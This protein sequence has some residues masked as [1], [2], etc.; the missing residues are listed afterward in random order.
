M[1]KTSLF[2]LMLATATSLH[3]QQKKATT[4]TSP[5]KPAAAASKL[6]KTADGYSILPSSLEYKF[7]KDAPGTKTAN[8]GDILEFHIITSFEDSVLFD[9][10]KM[11]GDKAVK[12]ALQP[13]A[14][15]G[16]VAEGLKLMTA[17]D[18]AIFRVL[19]DSM[20]KNGNMPLQPWM[21]LGKKMIYYVNLVSVKTAEEEKADLEAAATKQKTIDDQL[22]QDYFKK[23]NITAQK[24]PSGLY[25]KIDKE[26]TGDFAKASENV[27]VNYTGKLLNGETFDSNVDPAFQHV[28][29]FTFVL[30]TG[31]VIKGWDEGV[32][33][34]KEGGKATFYIPS[35]LAYGERSPSPK[36]PA[37]SVMVFDV[38]LKDIKTKEDLLKEQQEA[39][40]KAKADA[41][42]QKAVDEKLIKDYL[43]EKKIK[44]TRTASGLYYKIDKKGSGEVAKSG[45]RVTMNYTGKLL[46]GEAFDSNVD[47]TFGH[48]QPFEFL[49]GQHQVIQGWDEGIALFGKG[50]KATLYIPSGL[51]YG[52]SSPSP[53]IPNNSVLV[54]DVEVVEIKDA[55]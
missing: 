27:T 16:D 23:N 18:S 24:T 15:K 46:N 35:G 37:Y 33:L 48:V 2:L 30:G 43:A 55:Q 11:N 13:A 5:A 10:R 19:V 51:A 42:A 17:G 44:A 45:Q 21:K 22:L 47:A 40:T 38:E 26:G 8:D 36:I 49:L 50:T 31:N 53:K 6:P 28:Q 32:A 52:A 12:Y 25:Y 39:E 9:T 4:K 41:E 14:Y 20:Q 7:I 29:P 1:K 3:A 54:F 34:M